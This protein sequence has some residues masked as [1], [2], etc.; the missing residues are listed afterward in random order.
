MSWYFNDQGKPVGP[1][2]ENEI[3]ARLENG[4]LRWLDLLWNEDVKSWRPV[5]EWAEFRHVRLPA[6][7]ARRLRA[8]DEPSDESANWVVR[9]AQGRTVEGPFAT[10]RI[11]KDL[12]QGH[13][14]QGDL[15][16]RAGLAAWVP[17]EDCFECKPVISPD[18]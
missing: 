16:W 11:L 18:P 17:I 7:E 15:V 13:L 4:Q 10:S 2:Q 12:E 5:G 3:K 6:F 8:M 1:F 9:R 14:R